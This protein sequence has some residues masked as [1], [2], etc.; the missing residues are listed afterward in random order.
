[1][2]I[3]SALCITVNLDEATLKSIVAAYLND[4]LNGPTVSSVEFKCNQG[5]YGDRSF[6][7]ATATAQ[8]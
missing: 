3:P 5:G 2:T 6:Y 7:S 1:M 8:V 4:K